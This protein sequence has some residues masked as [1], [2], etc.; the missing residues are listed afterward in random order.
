VQQLQVQQLAAGRSWA[1][2]AA[3]F[4]VVAAVVGGVAIVALEYGRRSGMRSALSA[5]PQTA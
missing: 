1:A 5:A 2:S 4:A 3:S